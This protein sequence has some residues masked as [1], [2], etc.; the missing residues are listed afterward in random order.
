MPASCPYKASSCTPREKRLRQMIQAT[1]RYCLRIIFALSVATSLTIL[2]VMVLYQM[3]PRG[4]HAVLALQ[5]TDLEWGTRFLSSYLL[6][7]FVMLGWIWQLPVASYLRRYRSIRMTLNELIK[8]LDLSKRG[9]RLAFTATIASFVFL[10]AYPYLRYHTPIGIDTGS[11][12][13]ALHILESQPRIAFSGVNLGPFVSYALTFAPMMP[14]RALGVSW[15][16]IV[17]FSPIP[18]GLLYVLSNYAFAKWNFGNPV[19]VLT[20]MLSAL[21]LN[22]QLLTGVMYRNAMAISLFILLLLSYLRYALYAR[23]RDLF[24]V[25]ILFVLLL[26]QYAYMGLMAILVLF[27]FMAMSAVSLRAE[28]PRSIARAMC[29]PLMAP[30]IAIVLP[31]SAVLIGAW[32]KG[33]LLDIVSFGKRILLTYGPSVGMQQL[34][35]TWWISIFSQPHYSYNL[36]SGVILLL[37]SLG[38]LVLLMLTDLEPKEMFFRNM[39]FAWYVAVLV[40]FLFNPTETY[41]WVLVYPLPIFSSIGLLALCRIRIKP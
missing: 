41:R 4:G 36:E 13:L 31:T 35:P 10:K 14:L 23:R 7:Y 3:D 27:I 1:R 22:T 2:I 40:L 8:P 18:L 15:E 29:L 6:V 11:Y 28:F 12:V 30:I 19:A 25:D 39:L 9:L 33:T 32:E 34:M 37:S 16:I 21:S 5:L 20:A 17:A 26:L 24:L 38:I